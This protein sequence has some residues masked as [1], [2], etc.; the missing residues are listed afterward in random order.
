MAEVQIK[1][2]N[3]TLFKMALK[4]PWPPPWDVPQFSEKSFQI[5]LY[6]IHSSGVH[7]TIQVTPNFIFTSEDK[8]LS[9]FW[10]VISWPSRERSRISTPC[11]L[12]WQLKNL[13][14]LMSTEIQQ[15]ISAFN[16]LIFV[17]LVGT[18]TIDANSSSGKL[19]WNW[20]QS[21]AQATKK[22]MF[23][24]HTCPMLLKICNVLPVIV[25]QQPEDVDITQVYVLPGELSDQGQGAEVL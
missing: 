5:T 13:V 23:N 14:P 4:K 16:L 2:M 11:S 21:F 7:S 22:V 1:W 15:L 19:Q 3:D 10:P 8:R 20:N 6:N 9:A 12:D 24:T 25:Q 18:Y 17:L